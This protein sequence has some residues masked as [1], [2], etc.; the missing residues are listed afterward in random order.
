MVT[1][2]WSYGNFAIMKDIQRKC[3]LLVNL[4]K[5]ISNNKMLSRIIAICHPSAGKKKFYLV[6][7]VLYFSYIAL[8]KWRHLKDT[9]II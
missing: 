1:D 9:F 4:S 6:F 8:Y 2:I 3:N 5:F 7:L